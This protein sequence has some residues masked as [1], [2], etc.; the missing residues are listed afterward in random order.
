MNGFATLGVA[1]LLTLTLGPSAWAQTFT[2]SLTTAYRSNPRLLAERERVKEADETWV[3]ARALGRLSAN[4]SFQATP[5]LVRTP[6]TGFFGQPGEGSSTDSII[7]RQAG[8]QIVQPIYQG[9]RVS[10]QKRQAKAGILAARE[11]LRN[12]EQGI[13]QQAANAFASVIRDE[14]AA[15]IRRNNVRVLMR[16]KEAATV[17][18]DVGEGTRTDIALSDSRLALARIGLAQADAQLA[19]SRAQ[20]QAVIGIPPRQLTEVPRFAL[21]PTLPDA[22]AIALAANPQ[23]M[24]AYLN[25]SAADA[26]IDVAKSAGKPQISLNGQL[27][28]LREQLNAL[29]RAESAQITAQVTVPIFAGGANR[30]RV[31]QAKHAR[32]RAGFEARDAER[33]I[34]QNVTQFWAQI[35]AAK[36]SVLAARDQVAAAEIAF[37]GVE[38]EQQVGTRTALDVLDAEQE[39][40]NA[41]LNLVDA[42]RSENA[43]TFQLLALLGAFDA[44]S[45][46]LPVDVYDPREHFDRA[47]YEGMDEFVDDYVPIAIKKIGSQIPEATDKAITGIVDGLD[48]IEVLDAGGHAAEGVGTFLA[49]G[50]RAA[51]IGVDAVTGQGGSVEPLVEVASQ[52]SLEPD[53]AL[54][55]VIMLTPDPFTGER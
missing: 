4:A 32:N 34:R 12:V 42:E 48:A 27:G 16:Q 44:D 14:E 29:S 11:S 53:P 15:S 52:P 10:A 46:Q 33:A 20:F 51:K 19:T 50:A 30:S 28:I 54:P 40:A 24:Q 3:Q 25:Q 39:L 37:E 18:F 2:E 8:L 23:L 22:I 55:E 41:R 38:L 6:N 13:L 9:G 43:A 45:L 35:Q 47:K 21:P 31:R 49:G 7:S 26:G 1:L 5:T 36:A 17:R